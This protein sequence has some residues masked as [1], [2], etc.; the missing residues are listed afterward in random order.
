MVGARERAWSGAGEVGFHS[1]G[2][3]QRTGTP[4][5]A[6][7]GRDCCPVVCSGPAGK[8]VPATG[9]APATEAAEMGQEQR[10]IGVFKR[11]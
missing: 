2:A 1:R 7:V 9:D 10:K 11:D 5:S 3:A 8:Q 4:E 6:G